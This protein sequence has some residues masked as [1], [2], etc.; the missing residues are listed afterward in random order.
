[1]IMSTD[2]VGLTKIPNVTSKDSRGSFTKLYSQDLYQTNDF[3][4]KIAQINLSVTE[5][6]GTVRGLHYQLPPSSERKVI[7]CLRGRVFD[8]VVDIRRDSSSFL[9]YETFELSEDGGFALHVPTGCAHG[10]QVL[11]GPAEL[12]YLHS[13]EYRPDHEAGINPFDP[14]LLINWPVDVTQMSER[15]KSFP[16]LHKSFEGIIV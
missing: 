5:E 8:V 11:D 14:Q 13:E 4:F 6:I 10:F 3:D 2:I 16:S 7:R 15:D 9:K 12:L 1:M